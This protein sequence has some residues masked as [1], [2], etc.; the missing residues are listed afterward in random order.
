MSFRPW[1]DRTRTSSGRC[2]A[3][4]DD[5]AGDDN[6]NGKGGYDASVSGGNDGVGDESDDES[7]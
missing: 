2:L 1:V 4:G 6:D 7:S 3:N 5:E